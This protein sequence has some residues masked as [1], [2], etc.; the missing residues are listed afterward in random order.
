[1]AVNFSDKKLRP[2]FK[3]ESTRLLAAIRECEDLDRKLTETYEQMRIGMAR[4]RGA[5]SL[6]IRTSEQII[7]NRNHKLALIKELRSLKKDVVDR[8]IRLVENEN[9][10]E[11]LK[12][13]GG[14]SATLLAYLQSTVLTPGSS[15]A[16]L[17]PGSRALPEPRTTAEPQMPAE[18][19]RESE[20]QFSPGDVVCDRKGNIWVVEND[21]NVEST[22]IQAAEIV[23][24]PEDGS[25]PYAVL[26]DGR[27]AP[28]V[29][30]DDSK[31]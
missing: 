17:E 16:M 11:V 30:I 28:L 9:E 10:S 31:T 8:E 27:H 6:M 23:E 29:E 19:E 4:N 7:S 26:E 14:V 1:M 24:V 5:G 3:A 12:Q 18:G 2:D 21:G 25:A 22:D 13:A 15:S 20:L